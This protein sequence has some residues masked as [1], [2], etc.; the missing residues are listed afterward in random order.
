MFPAYEKLF[1]TERMSRYLTAAQGQPAAAVRLYQAN[2]RL[3]EALYSPLAL[4]E[5]A[6]RNQLNAVLQAH[7]RQSDWLL[8]QQTGFMR[9]PRFR[10]RNPRTGQLVVNDFL[11]RSVQGAE[12]KL[13]AGPRT[14]PSYPN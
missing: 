9:D 13:R 2:L 4:L 12:K 5:V 3:S 10:F 14:T 7:F 8:T 11:L 1:S 6:L